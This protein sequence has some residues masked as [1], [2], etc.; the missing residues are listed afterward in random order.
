MCEIHVDKLCIEWV[1]TGIV[2]SACGAWCDIASTVSRT[3]QGELSSGF[4]LQLQRCLEKRG[5]RANQML[6]SLK[7]RIGVPAYRAIWGKKSK[8]DKYYM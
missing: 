5:F 2:F 3:E 7:G 4:R 1:L 8:K 6:F